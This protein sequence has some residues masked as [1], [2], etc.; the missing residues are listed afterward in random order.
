MSVVA[1]P[2][3]EA[4]NPALQVIVDEA[5]KA[6]VERVFDESLKI[7][8]TPFNREIADALRATVGEKAVLAWEELV[9][10]LGF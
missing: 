10:D 3:T 7:S 6:L 5:V 8:P 2:K 4:V 1:A 9:D